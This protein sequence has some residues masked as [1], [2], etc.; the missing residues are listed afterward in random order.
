M[1]SCR[2]RA[3]ALKGAL[4]VIA[5]A[6]ASTF[7][8]LAQAQTISFGAANYTATEGGTAATVTVELSEFPSSAVVVD[9]TTTNGDNTQNADYTLSQA[10]LLFDSANKS[11]TFTVTAV[12][13]TEDEGDGSVV[14]GFDTLP[15][16][17][18]EGTQSTTTV[19]LVD[20]D[21]TEPTFSINDAS[22][23]EGEDI[24][25]T[26][27]L[28]ETRT[29]DFTVAYKTEI[30]T[31]DTAATN[32]FTAVSTAQTLTFTSSD[33]S[34]NITI[35]TTEDSDDEEDETF[36]VTLSNASDGSTIS[37]SAGS[38]TGTI[39]DDDLPAFSIA[40]ASATEGTGIAFTVTLSSASSSEVTVDYATSIATG[41]TAEAADFTAKSATT[42]SF[43]ANVTT[44]TFTI[45]TTIDSVDEEN[46]T[47]TVTLSN[48]SAGTEISSSA[49][50][51]TGTINDD[52]PLPVLTINDAIGS[53]D[54]EVDDGMDGTMTVA[55]SVVFTVTL[56]PASE[57]EVTVAYATST[58]AA[59]ET[60]ESGDLIGTTSGTLTFAAGDTSE[61][62]TIGTAVDAIDEVNE[63]F[64]VTLSGASNATI[65]TM[66]GSGTGTINDNDDPP[67][68]SIADARADEGDPLTFAVTLSS[69]SEMKVE[70]S[71]ATSTET[72]D[73][74]ATS[75]FTA[76]SGNLTF[77][78]SVTTQTFTVATIEDTTDE[79]DETFTVT[80]SSAMNAS[81][82]NATGTGTI[83]DDDNM[84]MLSISDASA[85]E[86]DPLTFTVTLLPASDRRVAVSY[87]TSPGTA[88]AGDFTAVSAT[89]MVFSAGVTTQNFTVATTEDTADEEDIE[90]FTVTL[91]G[92][93]GAGIS[94]ATGQGTINDD[95]D[96]PTVSI[97]NAAVVTEGGSAAFTVTVSP[98]SGKEITVNYSVSTSGT[99][100]SAEPA[101]LSSPTTGTLTI[102]AGSPTGSIA[103][104]TVNDTADEDDGET[105]SVNLTGATNAT[106]STTAATG[107]GSINDNDSPPALSINDAFGTEGGDVVFTVTA[108]SPSEKAVSV[109]YTTSL[110]GSG[111]RAESGDFTAISS[112]ATLS[113]TSS[114][115]SITISTT[116]DTTDENDETFTVTLS[117]PT[118]ATLSDSIGEGT[119]RDDDEP[120]TVSITDVSASESESGI[121]FEAV[122]SERREKAATLNWAASTSGASTAK[123][124]DL[125]GTLSGTLNFA[126]G[127]TRESFAVPLNRDNIDERDETFTVT[128][129][130]PPASNLTA[131][132]S[133]LAATG[134]IEDDDATPTVSL[135][136]SMSGSIG[137]NSTGNVAVTASLNH[138]ST[139]PTTVTVSATAVSPA[140][141]GDITLTGS[142]LTVAAEATTS[143]GTVTI[144]PVDNETDAPNKTVTVSATATNGLMI[145]APAN[146]T[147]T[148][149]DDDPVPVVT[150]MLT[151]PS[152]HEVSTAGTHVSTVTA[153]QDRPSSEDTELTVAAAAGDYAEAADFTLSTNTVLTIAAGSQMSTGT[154]TV[155]AEDNNVDSRD[156]TAT[157]SATATND[158]GIAGNPSNRTLAIVNDEVAPKVTLV[159]AD[160]SI[161]ESDDTEVSGN[162][163]VTTVR[164]RLDHPSTDE[165][166]V[167][168]TALAS[169]FTLSAGGVLTIPALATQSSGFVT[170]TAVDN[171]TDAP[172]KEL[173]LNA[174]AVNSFRIDQPD[175]IA[176]TIEDDEPPPTVTLE[177]TDASIEETGATTMISA[178]LSHPSSNETAIMVSAEAVSPAVN[179]DYTFVGS[180]LAIPAGQTVTSGSATITAVDNDTDAPDKEVTVSATAMNTQPVEGDPESLTLTIEDD[181]PAPA[182]TLHLSQ[183]PIGEAGGSTAV[184]AT[185]SHPS[186]ELT[187]ITVSS[188]AV[189]PAVAG[190]FSRVGSALTIAAGSEVSTGTVTLSAADND[191][192]AAD[193]SVT[194]SATARN[195][196]G[197][198]A[199]PSPLTLTLSDD[200]ERG[201]ALIPAQVS[202][203]EASSRIYTV[204][205]TSEPTAN[206]TV[207]ATTADASLVRLA[208]PLP[209]TEN[210]NEQANSRTLTFTPQN[211]SSAQRLGLRSQFPPD[212]DDH[213]VNV[214][215]SGAGGD[216]A[217]HQQNYSVTV[218]DTSGAST[219]I[220]LA[221]DVT[222]VEEGAGLTSI[223]VSAT[224]DASVRSE[225]TSV[226]VSVTGDTASAS[227]D[228][229]SVPAT[230]T[231]TIPAGR[232][233]VEQTIGFT[234]TQDGIDEDDE[235]VTVGG[236]TTSGLTVEAAT[237]T[238]LDDDTREVR[239][240]AE[241]LTVDEGSSRT[242]TVMLGSEPSGDV[243]VTPSVTGDADV[244]LTP[245]A[246]TFTAMNWS[247]AR[248]FTVTA[249]EDGDAV[250]NSAA[251]SHEVAGADYGSNAVTAPSVALTVDDNDGRGVTVSTR[252]LEVMEGGSATYT[253]VLNAQ[254]SGNVT[255]TPTVSGSADVTVEPAALTFAPGTWEDVQTVT[256]F[257]A[258]DVD[259]DDDRAAVSHAVTGADYEENGVTAP[260][261]LVKVSDTGITIAGAAFSVSPERVNEGAGSQTMTAQVWLGTGNERT[262]DT[263]VTV[264]VRS[265]TASESDFQ[266]NPAVFT[267][268][269]PAGETFGV[270]EFGLNIV[271]DGL[272]EEQE[273]ITVS[274]SATG[275]DLEPV[276]VTIVDNDGRG[277]DFSRLSL[278]VDEG[279]SET[280]EV[281]LSSQPT[282]TVE[283]TLTVSGAPEV[284]VSPEALTF[285]TADW[286]QA[287]EITVS[288]ALDPD[289]DDGDAT[290]THAASGGDYVGVMGEVAVTARDDR[291]DAGGLR[292]LVSP[293]SV[294]EGGES[295]TITVTAALIIPALA[296]DTDVTVSV[297][298]G[299]AQE[300][301]DFEEVA[302]FTI[303]LPADATRAQ[304]TFELTPIDDSIDEGSGETVQVDG[305]TTADVT[306]SGAQVTIVD[307][308]TASSTLTLSV[309][310][311]EVAEDATGA[312]QT[313][314]LTAELDGSA[315]AGSTDV[316]ISVAGVT[317]TAFD[318]FEGVDDITLTI[319]A[320][321]TSGQATFDLLPVNDDI[322]EAD[323][324]LRLTGTAP[325]LEV[326]PVAGLEVTLVDDDDAPQVSLVLVPETIREDSGT[327]TV[328]AMLDH[329]SSER[330]T[331]TISTTPVAPA[332]IQDVDQQGT[333]LTI[334]PG[335]TSSSGSVSIEAVDNAMQGDD[336]SFTVSARADNMLGIS[337]PAGQMLT[338]SDD[339]SPSTRVILEVSRRIIMEGAT[340]ADATLTVTATLDG[341]PRD[342]DT[343]VT[344]SVG[345]GTAMS[346]DDFAT[347][348][349]FVITIPAGGISA[350][351]TFELES[352][353]DEV[354]EPNETVSVSGTAPGLAVV[355][356]TVVI[357]ERAPPPQAIATL[358]ISPEQVAEEALGA[359]QTVTVTATLSEAL[360]EGGEITVSVFGGTAIEGEDFE[361]VSDITLSIE[362][363][364]TSGETTF[365]LIPV[366]DDVDEAHETV[367]VAG[368]STDVAVLP[369]A[370]LELA[371]VDN[372]E[373][374]VAVTP[375]LLSVPKGGSG[376]YEVVLTSQP[377]AVV[378]IDVSSGN[379]AV[380]ARPAQLVFA[381]ERWNFPQTVT[382]RVADDERVEDGASVELTHTVAGGDYAEHG[383]VADPV[384]VMV[385][386]TTVI[387][388]LSRN[389]VSEGATGAARTVGVTATLE[390]ETLDEDARITLSVS[391]GTA[392]VG[393]DF[394]AVSDFRLTIPAGGTTG[395]AS[396]TLMPVDDAVDEA[397]ETVLVMGRGPG[398]AVSPRDG[399]RVVIVD[400][401]ERGVSV[402]PSMLVVPR[403]RSGVY[404]VVLDTRPSAAVTIAVS[405]GNPAV[406]VSPASLTFAPDRWNVPQSVTV[407]MADDDRVGEGASVE[408]THSV[409]G[410]D[411]GD[412]NVQAGAV[413][414]TRLAPNAT[415]RLSPSRV[416]EGATGAARRVAVTATL[417]GAPLAEAVQV[418]VSVEGASAIEGVDFAP[419]PG[420]ALTI[421][422]GARSGEGSFVL[423]PVDDDVDEADETLRLRASASVLAFPPVTLTLEDDDER[424]VT[425]TPTAVAL[426]E[427]ATG[428]Y[429]VVLDSQPTA[430]ITVG[431]SSS[432]PDVTVSRNALTFTASNWSA[433]QAVS[434]SAGDDDVVDEDLTARL[435]HTVRGG[436]YEANDVQ[437]SGVRV[438]VYG[439]E[440][441][442][443][444]AQIRVPASGE[445]T[446]PPGTPVPAGTQLSLPAGL[447]GEIV[448]IAAVEDNPAL[449]TPPRG[450]NAGDPVV[451]IQL[452][453]GLALGSG[454]TATVCLPVEDEGR[455]RVYRYDDSSTPA[456]WLE[457]EEPSGGSP[458]GL[459]CGATDRLGLFALG[460]SP[461]E[462][463]ATSWLARIG[464]TIAQHVLE[465]VQERIAVSRHAGFA[466]ML[467]GRNLAASGEP[468]D[469]ERLSRIDGNAL[470]DSFDR[471]PAV[472][473]QDAL[474]TEPRS[475]D[476]DE[477]AANSAF[478]LTG[479]FEGG[480][481]LA[482]WGRGARSEFEGREEEATIDGDVSTATFGADW[483]SGRLTA[484]VAL[485]HS[486]GD[487]AWTQ[488]GRSDDLETTMTGAHPYFGYEVSERTSVWGLAGHGRGELTMSDGQK[489]IKSD[490]D[491]TMVAAGASSALLRSEPGSGLDVDLEADAMFLAIGA[492]G[493]RGLDAVEANVSRVRVGLEGSRPVL[494]GEGR[495]LTPSLELGFRHDGG[496][497]DTGAGFDIGAGIRWMDLDR[498]LST[499][500]SVRG[501]LVHQAEDFEEWGFSG[502]ITFD[503][504]R[505][506][507]RGL[508]VSLRHSM[509]TPSS[510]SAQTLF[511]NGT[512]SDLTG[513][514]GLGDRFDAEVVYGVPVFGGRFTGTPHAGFGIDGS[515]HDYTFGW[516]LTPPRRGDLDFTLNL[517]GTLREGRESGTLH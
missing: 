231:L 212:Q 213:M 286:D 456:E 401:D 30:G 100:E 389:R 81:I 377:S 37:S 469:L 448:T 396:F 150:L 262:T 441:E 475:P 177:L 464:R 412:N 292:L 287:R 463:V 269:I 128:L 247:Q 240:S 480:R 204:A 293:A 246:L 356:A 160:V 230:F 470:T 330:T 360:Q 185:Q 307:N 26:V 352:V 127:D 433:A 430:A 47:F 415:L 300:G 2:Q 52:D 183:N 239:V 442:G 468:A 94:D 510:G 484:G 296:M 426:L 355:E 451:D 34:K 155:T 471:A 275:L 336:K 411:Y 281:A 422:A 4:G 306:V 122:L 318:D 339:E 187:M 373:R 147:L 53:E 266:A 504:N 254:P 11:R 7:T 9:L 282:E 283:V 459:A 313:L 368:R 87:A 457:L 195:H 180:V 248:A 496:D 232:A 437:A 24:V 132:G 323:E 223:K 362:A 56:T 290:I 259:G 431:V 321:S 400:N 221:L 88:G 268:S 301:T 101:D 308:D 257:G 337:G 41:N 499:D 305:S 345:D 341:A 110:T 142:T 44:Q 58:T 344:V 82:S 197:I 162:Q 171:V 131:S 143:T 395:E 69:A 6:L 40:S 505:A 29:E 219:A 314:T 460:A 64:T 151:P 417:D 225:A 158:Q 427:G 99:A 357:S 218:T 153:T 353:E 113:L 384:S 42:L 385:S 507:D 176:L 154:V 241:S 249:A 280:Y 25:F 18:S 193:K 376:S 271:D 454:R 8:S 60:A 445:V 295:Q 429:R 115:G 164:A 14:V 21:K 72:G 485:S 447:G 404:Q 149:T 517:D 243:T 57:K 497:A 495:T 114:T 350:T 363:G 304:G 263:E 461:N 215:H 111:D 489:E 1:T 253:V 233:S 119:I 117:G 382:V 361:A 390:G 124:S 315:L 145:N 208:F 245:S 19:T 501:L 473:A 381:P 418:R 92:E 343:P 291:V 255:V 449:A 319:P 116:E 49:G 54:V 59:S 435:T 369:A 62:I 126:A 206:V 366:D 211:W 414:V 260:E 351:A 46:E 327:S 494:F 91:S 161:R 188:S 406:T 163:H 502:A 450:F 294:D 479:V 190:D 310:P 104:T 173:T 325:G 482:L 224:L 515:G 420:F 432:H 342:S 492:D 491:M 493:A 199:N 202:M 98:V 338:V 139:D 270:Q 458:E 309:S 172:H 217:G 228:F 436:D 107:S 403:G 380:S 265:G 256:V 312:A 320:A 334:L 175:G 210:L 152:I 12:N 130:L 136:L 201:Y 38:A 220:E 182:L 511:G 488:D 76:A 349:E 424:G 324:T 35:S 85:D 78:A 238:I 335:E 512:L 359:A 394:A 118:N 428:N 134:T 13:D 297:G 298:S 302:E 17:V 443:T 234:P 328:T 409:S 93:S 472:V 156:K 267:F 77:T 440:I 329:P 407:R 3:A 28:S 477:V 67:A 79:E 506:S 439:L 476:M 375:A 326:E 387:L 70:V 236:T 90:T 5:L 133:D 273:T 322:D 279:G 386:E 112:A 68:L 379:P 43:A 198:A 250:D 23:D 75:D 189:S 508:S 383:V 168:L 97:G 340:G 251:V 333:T 289:T 216:Y 299:S 367:V 465:A 214:L 402:T 483:A 105:F 311:T 103:I 144:A 167:T 135:S 157:V 191:I 455:R 365:S 207:T 446:V 425:V 10:R 503:P 252:D 96:P 141:G 125:S 166:T 89:E 170:L 244:T 278:V 391:G 371:I 272:D 159:L 137:E 303:T 516:R 63:T 237:L 181:E 31:D 276:D 140:V 165:T 490:I 462:L 374:G 121:T 86:G 66:D 452:G 15:A 514:A 509:G 227:D 398:V 258:Q 317:A 184:T 466:G 229:E 45:D 423:A 438:T 481:S 129:T 453:G 61:N 397:N 487:G 200:D 392:T 399:L 120:P 108:S 194:V 65:S 378:T 178:N 274:A 478:A 16:G 498:G 109:L 264:L 364:A 332:R 434:V 226:S 444:A 192:D 413:A 20:D 316:T 467:A 22:A 51:A 205:L 55:G 123:P 203:R 405:S 410:G 348:S 102:A 71:Y 74:A 500:L 83:D 372:D 235:T 474:G 32:D 84:S 50:S 408:L 196:Q 48:A 39:N 261:V 27:S 288:A 95:D 486:Q 388:S 73:S 36:T 285:T 331:L 370:G 346:G 138:P 347:V 419:V 33:T 277:L 242:Y 174:S 209:G 148:I 284:T 513:G 393:E 169:D 354:D 358:A 186:S 222:Q 106:V 416:S 80:L 179:T 421:P 146:Q